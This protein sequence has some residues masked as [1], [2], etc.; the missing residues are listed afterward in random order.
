MCAEDVSGVELSSIDGT[1]ARGG[2]LSRVSRVSM[3][4]IA[5]EISESVCR[6]EMAT[7]GSA[8]L[9]LKRPDASISIA[10]TAREKFT[11]EP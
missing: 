3:P 4:A 5:V 11:P 7:R 8:S 9:T 10:D 1:N 6:A 2:K